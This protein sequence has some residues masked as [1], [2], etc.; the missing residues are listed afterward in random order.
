M[1]L[2]T[3]V[4]KEVKCSYPAKELAEA[5]ATLN[6][7]I[8]EIALLEP[9]QPVELII[10]M[11]TITSVDSSQNKTKKFSW[12][13]ILQSNVADLTQPKLKAYAEARELKAKR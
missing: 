12:E 1:M 3:L 2:I 4:N 10:E 6:S 11:R 5:F 13:I 8:A 9:K 7:E